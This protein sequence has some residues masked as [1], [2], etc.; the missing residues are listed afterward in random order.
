VDHAAALIEQ[1]RLLGQLVRAAEP[2]TPVPTCPEWTMRKLVTHVGRG[3]RWVATIVRER[4]SGYVDTRTVP[5]GTPP[6]D[7]GGSVDW[8]HAG[9]R[10]VLD[11]V[12]SI[13]ADTP[14][15]TF[16]GRQPASW[17]VRRRLHETAVHRADA[18]FALDA[19]Y[20]LAPELAADGVSEWLTLLAARPAEAGPAALDDGVTLH[21]HATDSEGEWLVR[22]DGGRVTWEHGHAKG[23]A[24]VRG[25]ALDLLLATVGR[26]AEVEVLGE[27]TLWDTWLDRTRF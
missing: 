3:D 10:S 9:A 11:A 2:S 16:T 19:P 4:A 7:A 18:A 22:G 23:L 13:G 25:R 17:W 1:N 6:A 26:P 27:R 5:D 21:L 20:D 8:L 24:A 14:V 12:E 15:W